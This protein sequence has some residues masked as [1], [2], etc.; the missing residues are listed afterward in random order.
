MAEVW[1]VTG[2]GLMLTLSFLVSL[3]QT[4]H[5]FFLFALFTEDIG[6]LLLEGVDYVGTDLGQL[7]QVI[8]LPEGSVWGQRL[9]FFEK[10]LLF[11]PESCGCRR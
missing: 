9:D 2:R 11:G 10:V 1:E 3:S 7:D 4:G 8:E 6:R 5:Q